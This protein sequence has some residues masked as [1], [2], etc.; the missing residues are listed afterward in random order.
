MPSSW[1]D[2][3]FRY[4]PKEM[5]VTPALV[6]SASL[7]L[8]L[9]GVAFSAPPLPADG[10]PP[11]AAMPP[12]ELPALPPPLAGLPPA[13]A[14]PG[15]LP[16]LDELPPPAFPPFELPAAASPP[17]LTDP[18]LHVKPP[19][20]PADE[21]PDVFPLPAQPTVDRTSKLTAAASVPIVWR[22]VG[23]CQV[24][25]PFALSRGAECTPILLPDGQSCRICS[26]A[27]RNAPVA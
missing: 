18:P 12:T 27:S 15:L 9:R 4:P 8:L 16:P 23:L 1:K 17:A 20:G 25:L 19:C 2:S 14:L 11:A 13:S 26:P 5:M 24:S 6:S 22:Q 21:L 3:P 7:S 10:L